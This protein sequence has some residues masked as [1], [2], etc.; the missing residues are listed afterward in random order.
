VLLL[1]WLV[2]KNNM[3]KIFILSGASGNLGSFAAKYFIEKNKF[4]RYYFISRNN[5]YYDHGDLIVADDLTKEVNV[6]KAFGKI[7]RS[8]ENYY[9]LLNTIGGYW[10]GSEIADTSLSDWQRIIDINLTS[11]FLISKYFIQLCKTGLGGSLCMLSALSGVYPEVNKGAY[12]ISKNGINYLTKI[13]ALENRDKNISVNAIAPYIIDSQENREWVKDKS[14]LF[15]K[16][17]ICK[18][19]QEIF[20]DPGIISGNIFELRFSNK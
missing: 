20:D 6:E 19:A 5:V 16:E 4:E 17:N 11:S 9:C 1:F 13:L 2:S 10:G 8:E 12:S 3:K 15:P 14:L 18:L 7:D